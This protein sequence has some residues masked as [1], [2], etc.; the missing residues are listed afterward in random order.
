MRD[1]EIAPFLT[2][3]LACYLTRTFCYID[4]N[5]SRL[6]ISQDEFIAAH[7]DIPNFCAYITVTAH[8][9]YLQNA[10]WHSINNST[11]IQRMKVG[12]PNGSKRLRL[13]SFAPVVSTNWLQTSRSGVLLF[14]H[15]KNMCWFF[16]DLIPDEH[17]DAHGINILG[18]T[19]YTVNIT[20][21]LLF[22]HP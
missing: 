11:N 6:N 13:E 19:A 9:L 7:C 14:H 16:P 4:N 1:N 18:L 5:N 12:F 20:C 15:I 3:V 8:A 10:S 22:L 2:W 21:R 17:H